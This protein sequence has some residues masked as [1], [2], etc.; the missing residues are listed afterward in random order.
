MPPVIAVVPTTT[1][2]DTVLGVA[3]APSPR[4]NVA[5]LALVPLFKF[6]TGRLPVTPVVKGKPVA[7]VRVPLLGVPSTPPLTT[8]EPA[9]PTLTPSAVATPVPRFAVD[10][11]VPDIGK[12]TLVAA[13]KVS[14]EVYAP[15]VCNVLLSAKVRVAVVA[16][17]VTTTL[18]ILA[19]VSAASVV[20]PA[21]ANVVPTVR[22]PDIAKFPEAVGLTRIGLVSVGESEN[23]NEPVPE[24]G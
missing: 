9:E 13:V 11:K 1:D 17:A 21:T 18:L 2:P 6:V 3:H 23:T 20:A 8:K 10:S 15:T 16:G 12:V 24:V 22:L 4:Q 7:F 19:A 14:A 5:A